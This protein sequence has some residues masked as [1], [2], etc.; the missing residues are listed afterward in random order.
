MFLVYFF[1]IQTVG[2][3]WSDWVNEVLFGELLPTWTQNALEYMQVAG[4]LQ[5]LILDG[6][7]AGIGA[8][9]GFLPQIFV[10]FVCWVF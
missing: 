4:W 1:S 5:S 10:L 7:L 3:M 9:L 8:V 2:V 6:I